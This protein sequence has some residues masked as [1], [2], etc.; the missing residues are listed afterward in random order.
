MNQ[1]DWL[2]YIWIYDGSN[3]KIS[4]KSKR[5]R[6]LTESRVSIRRRTP[7]KK[8]S[9]AVARK[10]NILGKFPKTRQNF[11]NPDKTADEDQSIKG[12]YT[13]RFT[14][15]WRRVKMKAVGGNGM[16][17]PGSEWKENIYLVPVL[18]YRKRHMAPPGGGCSV[19]KSTGKQEPTRNRAIHPIK[20][21]KRERKPL[22]L[23]SVQQ[24]NRKRANT[25]STK[26]LMSRQERRVRHTGKM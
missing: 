14:T 24:Q 13:E 12:V 21:S 18:L 26:H 25:I 7:K 6:Y 4:E 16:F 20:L 22:H 11:Q 1:S 23:S 5:Q 2:N 15:R 10:S 17:Q 8:K 19:H 3:K 9:L